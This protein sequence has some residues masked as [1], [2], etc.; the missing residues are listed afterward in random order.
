M[1][2]CLSLYPSVCF[3]F[4]PTKCTCICCGKC[5]LFE[6]LGL[7]DSPLHPMA[8]STMALPLPPGSPVSLQSVFLAEFDNHIGPKIVYQTPENVLSVDLF[9]MV[10]DFIITTAELCG[11]VVTCQVFNQKIMSYCVLF[12][13]DKY[14]RGTL[15]FSVGFVFDKT[16][17]CES[18]QPV[19]SKFGSVLET[20]EDESEFVSNPDTKGFLKTIVTKIYEKMNSHGECLLLV[21]DANKIQLKLFPWL[22][23]PPMVDECEVPV[24]IRDIETY[25]SGEWDLTLREVIG[26]I[27][28]FNTVKHIAQLSGMPNLTS[29]SCVGQ[30]RPSSALRLARSACSC[31][32]VCCFSF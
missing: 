9:D 13:D 4:L 28:N 11:K 25:M 19:L 14:E 12:K 10:S 30:Q 18:Y 21:N 32:L 1:L 22:E 5:D 29:N 3:F 15:L 8:S 6:L 17:D 23:T 27:D 20:L 7:P 31:Y 26:F 2:W 24:R 16:F